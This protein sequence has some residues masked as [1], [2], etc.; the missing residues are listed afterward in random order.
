[1]YRPICFPCL[2]V[3]PILG[4]VHS[5]PRKTGPDTINFAMLSHSL[6]ERKFG[7]DPAIVGKNIRLRD[8]PY[9]VVGVMPAGFSLLE[10]GVDVYVPLALNANDPRL[11]GSRMLTVVARLKPGVTL[12]PGEE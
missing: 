9:D 6:W 12:G 3:Q 1:M 10:P 5:A 2:G 8:Q 4:R 11:A 7:A